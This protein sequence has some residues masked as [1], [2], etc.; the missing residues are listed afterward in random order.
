MVEPTDTF[1]T[2]Q[3]TRVQCWSGQW[4]PLDL[5]FHPDW[6][7]CSAVVPPGTLGGQEVAGGRVEPVPSAGQQP[8]ADGRLA[9]HGQVVVEATVGLAGDH[10]VVAFLARIDTD[11]HL[12]D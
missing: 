11:V 3:D 8:V 1:E 9:P 4:A 12:G 5:T 6:Y 7:L 2:F 10:A